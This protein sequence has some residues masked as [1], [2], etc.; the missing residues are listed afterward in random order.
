MLLSTALAQDVNISANTVNVI[1]LAVSLLVLL[2][3]I[4]VL[5]VTLL[6][7]MRLVRRVDEQAARVQ[8]LQQVNTRLEKTNAD[9]KTRVDKL[10]ILS[11]APNDYERKLLDHVTQLQTQFERQLQAVRRETSDTILAMTLMPLGAQQ[12]RSK[13]VKG[14]LDT[15][16]RALKLDADSP[17][18]HYQI[19]YIYAQ[20]GRLDEAQEYLQ[21]SLTF[22][23]A[24]PPAKAALGYVFRRKGEAYPAGE[25]REQYLFDG[26][27]SLLEALE[28][29]PR[30][31]DEEGESWW[32]VLGG[33][34]RHRGQT[35]KAINAYEEAA[36]ITPYSS[37]PL[38]QLAV[39]Q[40]TAGDEA[41]MIQTY[42]DVERLAR[43]QTQ[44]N[45]DNYWPY[46]DLMVARLALGKIQEAE[47]VLKVVLQLIPRDLAYAANSLLVT[48]TK[49]AKLA[50]GNANSIERVVK[51][52]R[53]NVIEGKRLKD[54]ATL[55]N[56]SFVIPF[57]GFP[58]VAVRASNHDDPA[59]L[60]RILDLTEQRPSIYIL[61]G[62]MD[63]KSKE[64][65]DTRPVIENGLTVFAQ[66]NGVAV[67]DGGTASGV[68]KLMGEARTLHKATFP[69]IGVAPINLVRYHGYD[70]PNGYDLDGGHSHFVFTSEGDWGDETDMIVQ[71]AQSLSGIGKCRSLGL[72][73]NGGNIV[74][75]EVYRLSVTRQLTL[76]MLVLEG[77]GRFADT[78]AAAYRSGQ[79]EDNDLLEIVMRGKQ[80]G[81]ME[82]IPV[83]A[84]PQS[85]VNRLT[86]HLR[87][88][89]GC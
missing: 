39:Q 88:A 33:L 28:A 69:L 35:R 47:E 3:G 53:E 34:Y 11:E 57:D 25:A 24:Y 1:S 62:A 70:N 67:V 82:L 76:P 15:Y 78:L 59:V 42:R 4:L 63:M 29:A 46:A 64:M 61:G 30:L 75:Q 6:G 36:K 38:V 17:V 26:E 85:F 27:T 8:Q 81:N 9:L 55:G 80:S 66:Q 54:A 79:S 56:E 22:D 52:I 2:V 16:Q 83:S 21:K 18:I 89:D 50:P 7:Y 58:A 72:V 68:M 65:Q 71:L 43:Q 14:A 87:R 32:N 5:I 48:L 41:A 12:Y 84:G 49:L 73:I 60:T 44:A 10:V 51:Y 86:H 23:P 74:R 31:L 20:E 37:Y 19:G 77:S 40:G 13:D 45:P